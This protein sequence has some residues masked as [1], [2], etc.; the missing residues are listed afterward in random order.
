MSL[1]DTEISNLVAQEFKTPT[2]AV[3]EQYLEIHQPV[4]ENSFVKIARI[5]RDGEMVIV[6]IPVEGEYFYFAVYI[7]AEKAEVTGFNTESRN[8]VSLCITSDGLDIN[9]L[10][11]LTCIN[12][13]KTWNK[14][15]LRPNKKAA[16]N[17]TLVEYE[18]NP[19]PDQ[20]EDKLKK[21]LVV[22]SKE[23][24]EVNK[25]VTIANA[26]VRVIMDFHAGNQLLGSADIDLECLKI[27]TELNLRIR[28][29]FAAWGE[30]FK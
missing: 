18:P 27:I 10:S 2:L 26:Y 23:K 28:F 3:T 9:D 25:L 20:F 22:L 24:A 1:T 17:Y 6:Y 19:E 4:Y 11:L 13:T 21:L 16:Y 30:P 8:I 12:P 15:D 29:E 7:D 5:D 14:G